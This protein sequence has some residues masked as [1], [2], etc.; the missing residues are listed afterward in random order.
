MV[1]ISNHLFTEIAEEVGLP[2]DACIWIVSN[3]PQSKES[4]KFKIST[5]YM[6]EYYKGNFSNLYPYVSLNFS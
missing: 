6:N 4:L 5:L 2:P 1:R 3:K